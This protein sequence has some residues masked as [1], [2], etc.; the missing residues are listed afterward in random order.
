M[1]TQSE[2]MEKLEKGN[3]KWLVLVVVLFSQ[4]CTFGLSY[5][6]GVLYKDWTVYFDSTASFLS[7]VGSSPTAI[8]CI[9]GK[10]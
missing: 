3:Y 7:L 2:N 9:S 4:A 1:E 6:A 10:L 8:A 5:S